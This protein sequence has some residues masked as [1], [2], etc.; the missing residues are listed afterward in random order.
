MDGNGAP[1]SAFVYTPPT[2]LEL[3]EHGDTLFSMGC[4][5]D[6]CFTRIT[7]SGHFPTLVMEE[8][9]W[10]QVESI[11]D[12]DGDGIQELLVATSWFT[13]TRSSLYLYSY[14][15]DRWV[16]QEKVS[17]RNGDAE[18]LKNQYI[19]K[20]QKRYLIGIKSVD[21]DEVEW[22]KEIEVK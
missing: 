14:K 4:K 15:K 12:I 10:G 2:K 13:T 22:M 5:N 19:K 6:H 7:F 17:F 21:G 8:S 20:G 1:D 3:D 11:D 18:P 9:V 16:E